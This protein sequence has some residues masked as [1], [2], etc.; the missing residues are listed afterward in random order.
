LTLISRMAILATRN[1]HPL[2]L[3]VKSFT[4]QPIVVRIFKPSPLTALPIY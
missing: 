4:T 1:G 3:N 2:H